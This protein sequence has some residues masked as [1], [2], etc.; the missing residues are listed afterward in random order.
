MK[1]M[2]LL[3]KRNIK[4]FIKDKG[5]FFTSLVT[6]VIL[7]VLY[8]SFLGDVY[9]D[10][11]I[12]ALPD[13]IVLPDKLI[14]GVVGGQLI[15][16]ILAV[17]CITVAFCANLIM[18]RDKVTGAKG[19]FTIAPLKKSTMAISYFAATFF[20]TILI[21]FTALIVCL[22][23]VAIVGWYF[24]F[25]DVLL[26][27][28]DSALLTLFGTA[29]S[30]IVNYPLKTN[31][32]ASAVGTIVSAGYGFISGAY[33]PIASLSVGLQ[34]VVGFL[35]GTYGTS[36]LRN[37]GLSGALQELAAQ[38]VPADVVEQIK[39]SV[40]CNLYFFNNLVS[41]GQVYCI[42][43]LSTVALVG[44]Y[45]LMNYFKNNKFKLKLNKLKFNKKNK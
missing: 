21:I 16:S 31:G 1:T 17:S 10:V 2:L 34:R 40:D 43:I 8:V 37:R 28:V 33:M 6:P 42:L 41:I 18:V 30:S 9:R 11:L 7:L 19:D 44:I 35:P 26:L 12:S 24:S 45:V 15:S 27:F 39:D 22:I 29:V 23:Y 13:G 32:Q 4:L 25:T 5:M 3:T 38:G 36:L 20:V 14:G